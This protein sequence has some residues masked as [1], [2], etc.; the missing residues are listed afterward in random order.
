ME[1]YFVSGSRKTGFRVS[2]HFPG[3]YQVPKIGSSLPDHFLRPRKT[4]SRLR[5]HRLKPGD[6]KGIKKSRSKSLNLK[7]HKCWIIASDYN[8]RRD[9]SK[10]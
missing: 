9:G 1:F 10:D 2:H 4:L 6:L 7:L 3:T 5:G 8:G